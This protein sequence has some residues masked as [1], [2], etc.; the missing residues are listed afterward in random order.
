MNRERVPRPD[1]AASGAPGK[2]KRRVMVCT[3]A[4][5]VSSGAQAVRNA[6]Q[7]AVRR[8]L[9]DVR[10]M[11]TGC[12]GPCARGPMVKIDP[13]D[14]YYQGLTAEDVPE[15][16]EKHLIGGEPVREQTVPDRRAVLRQAAQDR[17]GER[18]P[19]R[20]RADRGLH[21]RRRL[22]RAL[23]AIARD[24][25]RSRSIDEVTQSACAAAAAPASPPASSGASSPRPPGDR[26]TSS[27]TATRATPAPSWTARVLE[28]D[29]HRVLE[30]MA[31]AG[32]AVG[33]DQG[34]IYVRGEYPLAVAA[35]PDG[36]PPGRAARPARQRGSSTRRSAS[37]STSGWAPA[38]SSA[39]RRPR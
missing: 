14:V 4:G 10:V 19:D 35:P 1:R 37:E 9:T 21:R 34:Y 30:G 32:Y 24:D 6:F 11:G 36:D 12:L 17:P 26:S 22:R 5:C 25:A 38:R 20:P 2:Y 29:P 39:A 31:I 7:A 13:D 33:A 8:K 16:V 3:S 28:G 15:I 23:K 27:A 18:G